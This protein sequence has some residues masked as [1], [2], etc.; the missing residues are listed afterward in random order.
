MIRQFLLCLTLS[1]V[2]CVTGCGGKAG[3]ERYFTYRS[4]GFFC[5]V[6]GTVD[7]VEVR[8]EITYVPKGTSTVHYLAPAS[9]R[10]LCV[11]SADGAARA[12]LDGLAF[13]ADADTLAGLL[14]PLTLLTECPCEVRAVK[15]TDG[16]TVLT[17]SDETALTLSSNGVPLSVAARGVRLEVAAFTTLTPLAPQ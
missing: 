6:R 12:M 8:A 10:G 7:G 11:K 14:R 17:L 2:L 5:E 13:A 1:V 3:G 15:R 4:E 9:L 16:K